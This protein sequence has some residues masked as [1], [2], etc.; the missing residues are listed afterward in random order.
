MKSRPVRILG[1]EGAGAYTG[2]LRGATFWRRKSC[3]RQAYTV[4][5]GRSGRQKG[6]AVA[7]LL[8]SCDHAGEARAS[9]GSVAVRGDELYG[10]LTT[11][12]LHHITAV[13]VVDVGDPVGSPRR[14]EV[15]IVLLVREVN[16]IP[17]ALALDKV[18]APV[19]RLYAADVFGYTPGDVER[20]ALACGHDGLLLGANQQSISLSVIQVYYHFYINMSILY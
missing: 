17:I 20:V 3:V 9:R 10:L 8:S 2:V 16:D 13:V 7:P 6:W 18:D 4:S 15:A 1:M 5:Y 19:V 11:Y 14:L 12:K